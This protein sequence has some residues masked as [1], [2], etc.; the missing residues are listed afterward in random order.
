MYIHTTDPFQCVC[1]QYKA[2][3]ST[4]QTSVAVAVKTYMYNAP[5]TLCALQNMTIQSKQDCRGGGGW[6]GGWQGVQEKHKMRRAA[7]VM[8]DAAVL[9]TNNDVMGLQ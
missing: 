8:Q 3:T 6:K 4:F 5:C 7:F 9:L 1:R 2:C